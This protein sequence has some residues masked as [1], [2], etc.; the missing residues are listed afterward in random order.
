MLLSLSNRKPLLLGIVPVSVFFGV[1]DRVQRI[2]AGPNYL[3]KS[4]LR[5]NKWLKKTI[6][7]YQ[8][9]FITPGRGLHHRYDWQQVA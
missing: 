3:L 1:S 8:S 9:Y 4:D 7:F 2:V 5:S 6:F